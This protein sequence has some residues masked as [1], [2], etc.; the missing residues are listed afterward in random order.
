MGNKIGK[1]RKAI[2]YKKEIIENKNTPKEQNAVARNILENNVS[3]V[4][5]DNEVKLALALQQSIKT[6]ALTKLDYIA[7]L[8]RLN[9]QRD[10]AL[11]SQYKNQD[12][13]SLIRYELYTK[14]LNKIANQNNISIEK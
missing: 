14:Q 1:K 2:E 13:I 9:P 7:I 10:N 12:L 4:P 11:I 6:G 3:G 8:V 5:S